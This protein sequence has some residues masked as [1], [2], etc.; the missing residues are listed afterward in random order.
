MDLKTDRIERCERRDRGTHRRLGAPHALPQRIGDFGEEQV[1]HEKLVGALEQPQR[2][3]VMR[4]EHEP[5]DSDAR[6]H[7]EVAHRSRASRMSVVLSLNRRP[8]C[9]A[10]TRLIASGMSSG[11]RAAYSR[12]ALSSACSERPFSLARDFKRS[13]TSGASPRMSTSGMVLSSLASKMIAPLS[14]GPCAVT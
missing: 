4:L 6:V 7:D 12:M 10:R 13:T 8:R 3:C 11:G 1:R 14:C 5:L 9:M 2:R